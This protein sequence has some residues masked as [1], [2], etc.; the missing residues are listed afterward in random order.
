MALPP[1]LA[2]RWARL[3]PRERVVVTLALG[4]IALALVWW[5]ALAPALAVLGGAPARH[6]ALDAELARMQGLAAQA[7]ALQGQP[8]MG[9]DDALRALEATVRAQLGTGARVAVV[10]E[11]VT[12]T[13]A[14][15]RGDALAQW[16]TQA[17]VNARAL[18]GEA[19]LTRNAAGL[20]DGTVVVTLPPR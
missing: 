13:L 17:R 18:P 15:V 4:L 20:W 16:L 14:G 8:R 5:V 6:A 9:Q 3:A 1:V 12:L 7:R 19:R 2:A 11:R 10:G